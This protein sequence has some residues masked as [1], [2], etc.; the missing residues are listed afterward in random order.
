LV[1]ELGL[2][3]RVS[4]PGYLDEPGPWF[5]AA[6]LFVLSSDYE[7]FGNVIVEALEQGTPVVCTDC[8]S[9]PREI[10]QDGRFGLLVPPGDVDALAMGMRESLHAQHDPCALMQRAG[11]FSIEKAARA[12][13]GLLL[14]EWQRATS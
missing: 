13:L 14:P 11:E 9:G 3:D 8:P 12:Y 1:S 10:L 7:G 2:G 4:L 5:S 6:D